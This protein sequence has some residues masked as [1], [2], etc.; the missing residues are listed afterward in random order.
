MCPDTEAWQTFLDGSIAQGE[1]AAAESHLA[2]CRLCRERLIGLSD[3]GR[4]N[5]VPEVAPTSLRKRAEELV[6]RTPD[7]PSLFGSLR[8]YVPLALAA[9]IVLA[10]GLSVMVFRSR[11]ERQPASELRQSD[12]TTVAL[13]L[14][15]PTDGAVIE[16]GQMEFRWGSAGPGARYEFTITDEKGDI[17]FHEKPANTLLSLDS[18]AL[19]LSPQ[20]KYYWTVSARLPDGTKRESAVAGFS[21][22]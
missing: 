13:S 6:S 5:A 4:E 20:R 16:P 22:K 7:S 3:A 2:R 10:V 15:S 11:T 17:V 9:A 19:R 14:S 18:R 12:L 21:L 1:R 8:P